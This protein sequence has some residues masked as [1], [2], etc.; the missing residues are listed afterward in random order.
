MTDNKQELITK[1]KSFFN[2][3]LD[4][5]K[6]KFDNDILNLEHMKYDYFDNICIPFITLQH[7]PQNTEQIY[8]AIETEPNHKDNE[9][10]E[11]KLKLKNKTQKSS[12]LDIRSK[13]PIP[14]RKPIKKKDNEI[15]SKT[16][17]V[18]KLHKDKS[19]DR[20][21]TKK[22]NNEHKEDKKEQLKKQTTLTPGIKKKDE[23]EPKKFPIFY[24]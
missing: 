20:T 4:T 12:K 23:K 3:K 15:N 8:T 2:N 18:D 11:N 22:K 19:V 17:T 10:T 6:S 16:I 13:T 9:D 14:S 7:P 1:L 24:L 21:N 5:L